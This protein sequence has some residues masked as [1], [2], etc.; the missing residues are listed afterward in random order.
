[1]AIC[2]VNPST[3]ISVK[4]VKFSN[5]INYQGV[6]GTYKCTNRAIAQILEQLLEAMSII[7]KILHIFSKSKTSMIDQQKFCKNNNLLY[8]REKPHSA[9]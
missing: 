4:V 2:L 6:N 1:M 8:F 5:E 3:E 9:T 7:I